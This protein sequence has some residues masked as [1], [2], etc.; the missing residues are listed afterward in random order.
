LEYIVVYGVLLRE[1]FSRKNDFLEI[2]K[3]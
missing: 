1:L 2:A 3:A